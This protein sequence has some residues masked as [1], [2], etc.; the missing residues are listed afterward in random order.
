MKVNK[1]VPTK[2]QGELIAHIMGDEFPFYYSQGYGKAYQFSHT[3]LRRSDD[4]GVNGEVASGYYDACITLFFKWCQD[5][6]VS[7]NHLYRAAINCTWYS[8]LNEA[9]VNTSKHIDHAFEHKV[10]LLYLNDFD[11]GNVN[12]QEIDGV[13]SHKPEMLDGVL[14]NGETHW[15]DS[16]AVN[17]RRVAMVVTFD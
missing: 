7:V 17:Q 5:N 1:L 14:F 3:L 11:L 2:Q 13:K 8:E 12:V 16:C 6:N 4:K 15:I 10:W 9:Q